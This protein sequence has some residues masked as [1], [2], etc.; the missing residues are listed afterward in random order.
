MLLP[1]GTGACRAQ[2]T[3]TEYECK[4]A[5]SGECPSTACAPHI[6]ANLNPVGPF[7]CKPNDG[8]AY[9]GCHGLGTSCTGSYCC[10]KDANMNEF[11]ALPCQ[12]DTM[13]GAAHCNPYQSASGICIT[14]TQACGP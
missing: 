14:V 8:Q 3:G 6:D 1:D 13:C 10:M 9:D 12:N 4:C 11:C 5:V 7:V 2:P